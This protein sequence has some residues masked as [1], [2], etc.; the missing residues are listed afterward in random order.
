M[1]GLESIEFIDQESK[2]RKRNISR[3]FLLLFATLVYAYFFGGLFPY[4]LLYM[5]IALPI[6]SAVHLILVCSLFRLSERVN[7]RTF[8]KGDCASYW[9]ILHNSSF[10]YMPY[11]TVH[12]QMEGKFIMKDVKSMRLSLAPFSSREFKYDMPLPYRGRYEIGVNSIEVQD[13]LGMF[14]YKILS[15]EKKSILVKPRLIN[16]DYKDIPV[17]RI[18]EGDL[19]SGFQEIGNDEL[20]DIREY[21]YGDSLRKMHWKLT[22][23]LSKPMVKDTRNELD[24]DILVILNLNQTW[25]MDEETLKKEDCIIEELVSQIYYLLRRNVPVK[26]CFYNNGPQSFRAS[27]PLE[28]ESIYQLL[29]EIKFNQDCDFNNMLDYFTDL[30]QNSNLVYVFT[31]LV[32]GDMISK[33]FHVK[34]KGFDLELYYTSI[35]DVAEDD[36][37]AISDLSDMLMRSNIRSYH[38][39]PRLIEA[40]GGQQ[41]VSMEKVKVKAEVEAYEAPIG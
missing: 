30:E 21:V 29:A 17:A 8:V 36:M 28:F 2:N 3:Y 25:A 12:M 11:V 35:Q 26:L 10:L 40:A 14:A 4:T 38:L 9:L 13:L 32:D 24:N 1:A 41:E 39:L 16:L 23:K 34:N 31:N 7:D 6:M 37:K 20:R 19:A 33:A 18:S 5:M 22:S 15:Y 27:T